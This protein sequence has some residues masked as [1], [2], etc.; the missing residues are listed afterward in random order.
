MNAIWERETKRS[1]PRQ[2]FLDANSLI[3]QTAA[4]KSTEK[5]W[6]KNA[7]KLF[8]DLTYF[9][10]FLKRDANGPTVNKGPLARNGVRV[11]FSNKI[12]F[13]VRVSVYGYTRLPSPSF[14][15]SLPSS[16]LYQKKKKNYFFFTTAGTRYNSS[17][18]PCRSSGVTPLFSIVSCF[19]FPLFSPFVVLLTCQGLCTKVKVVTKMMGKEM[20]KARLFS[21]PLRLASAN[22][23]PLI[24]ESNRFDN[25]WLTEWISMGNNQKAATW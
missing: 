23:N 14:T 9:C 15:C 3:K 10:H 7:Y 24:R 19:F 1:L 13:N 25:R 6:H 22:Y 20:R 5:W 8:V 4:A 16:A 2:F 12:I 18:A 17:S 21:L 11:S